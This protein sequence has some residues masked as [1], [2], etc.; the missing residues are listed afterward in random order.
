MSERQIKPLRKY[1]VY[2]VND[3]EPTVFTADDMVIDGMYHTFYN[4]G[5]VIRVVGS[6][7]I[8]QVVVTPIDEA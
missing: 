4:T 5:N 7:F 3:E 2:F 8:E 1:E 6:L